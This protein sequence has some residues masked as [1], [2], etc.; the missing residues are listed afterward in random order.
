[1]T[2]RPTAETITDAELDALY[3]KLAVAEQAATGERTF[4]WYADDAQRRLKVQH[5]RAERAEAAIDR[6]RARHTRGPDGRC[7]YCLFNYWPCATICLLDGPPCGPECEEWHGSIPPAT[8]ATEL[9]TTARVF[10]GLHRSA[11]Q[12]VSRVIALYE[13]WV[14][15]GAPPLGTSMARWWDARLLE[16]RDAILPPDQTTT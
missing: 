10:A 16:L 5:E 11:D 7:T 6:V 1:M 9:D 2:T 3:R 12:D 8:D 13:Q 4:K 15:A 14:K